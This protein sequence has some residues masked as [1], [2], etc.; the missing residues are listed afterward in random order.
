MI[1]FSK[2]IKMLKIFKHQKKKL[3]RRS[4]NSLLV[5]SI[6]TKLIGIFKEDCKEEKR[7][8]ERLKNKLDKTE[9]KLDKE[10]KKLKEK[11]KKITE[12]EREID[13]KKEKKW[14]NLETKRKDKDFI[15]DAISELDGWYERQAYW[16][17][18]RKY[19]VP[20][21]DSFTK[22]VERDKINQKEYINEVFDCDNYSDHLVALFSTKYTCNA[23]GTIISQDGEPHAFNVVVFPDGNAELWEPQTDEFVTESDKRRYSLDGALIRI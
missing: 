9:S 3:T 19:N 20:T 4:Y 14:P 22:V 11:E 21:R 17:D 13:K 16:W 7:K 5:S 8:L 6:A 12:L 15:E 10:S 1:Y 18:D 23:V 2:F